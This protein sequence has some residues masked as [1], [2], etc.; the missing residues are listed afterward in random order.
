MVK[1]SAG[2][3]RS[4]L[5]RVVTPPGEQARHTR[6]SLVYFSRPEHEVVM[7]RASGGTDR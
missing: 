1:F 7:K 3:L 5:H 6:Y 2:I 4:N